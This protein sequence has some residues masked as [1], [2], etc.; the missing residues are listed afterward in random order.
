MVRRPSLGG[1]V[2]EKSAA[3]KQAVRKSK[4]HS[5]SFCETANKH[6]LLVLCCSSLVAVQFVSGM[7]AGIST[8]QSE[9]HSKA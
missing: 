4:M 9:V 8:S 2:W 6:E 5:T 7:Q 3:A 1:F